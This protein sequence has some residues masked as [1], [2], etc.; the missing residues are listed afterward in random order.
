MLRQLSRLAAVVALCLLAAH[1]AGCVVDSGTKSSGELSYVKVQ[2][3]YRLHAAPEGYIYELWLSTFGVNI[4]RDTVHI[5]DSIIVRDS[6]V[7]F[8]DTTFS[9][10]RFQWDPY[11]YAATDA[12]GNILPM[13]SGDGMN[14]GKD[15]APYF[16]TQTT[17]AFITTEPLNDPLPL[18]PNFPMLAAINLNSLSHSGT[19]IN[20]FAIAALIGGGAPSASFELVSQ[21]NKK[22]V[23]HSRWRD[24]STEG[25]G[26]WFADPSVAQNVVVDTAGGYLAYSTVVSPPEG[27]GNPYTYTV[28]KK[29]DP[30]FPESS[31]S[32]FGRVFANREPDLLF[33]DGIPVHA[34]TTKF[35]PQGDR[36]DGNPPP[37][38]LGSDPVVENGV[39]V[40]YRYVS[41]N[42]LDTCIL[43]I[44]NVALTHCNHDTISP[45]VLPFGAP[46]T[47]VRSFSFTTGDTT[48]TPTLG[49]V[50][51]LSDPIALNRLLQGNGFIFAGYDYEAWLVFTQAS[52]IKPLSLG[53]FNNPGHADEANTYTL[54]GSNYDSNFTFPGEDFLQNLP[55]PLT[56]PLNVV[57]DPRVE[58]LWI[59]VQP[60]LGLDPAPDE[61]NTQLIYLSAYIPKE[62]RPDRSARFSLVYQNLDPSPNG[63]TNG[64][65]FP[66]VKV[67]F[68]SGPAK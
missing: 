24:N 32:N 36:R 25:Y 22:S 3:D 16:Q 18:A 34:D 47:T 66:S 4:I 31:F 57:T 29:L 5:G 14:L 42:H 46:D 49:G 53:R 62:L 37:I 50:L 39:T 27:G 58:K 54:S 64:N 61:P 6:A 51:N 60:V 44:D 8:I 68:G 33:S 17:V 65:A 9:I 12:Q 13:T 2:P 11:L 67:S 35:G 30:A 7:V 40:G 26:I 43:R 10:V 56:A 63:L 1:L 23:P 15:L 21:S 28:W 41:D 52:G 38:S 55:A 19:L 20:P 45:P 59:T 48:V